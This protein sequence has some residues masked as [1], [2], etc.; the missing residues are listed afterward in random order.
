MTFFYR[1][2]FCLLR[3]WIKIIVYI[4][5]IVTIIIIVVVTFSLFNLQTFDA[6]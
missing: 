2:Y 6:R 5:M 3:N 1:K 4:I